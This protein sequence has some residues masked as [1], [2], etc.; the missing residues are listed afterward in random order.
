MAQRA[1]YD[2]KDVI[3]LDNQFTVDFFWNQNLVQEIPPIHTYHD[4]AN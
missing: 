3:L 4:Y 2:M 1:E